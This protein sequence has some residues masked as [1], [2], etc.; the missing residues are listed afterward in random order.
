MNKNFV[1]NKEILSLNNQLFDGF[2]IEELEVR[3]ETDPLMF[4]QFFGLSPDVDIDG[5]PCNNLKTCPDLRC[6]I[7]S[8]PELK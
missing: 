5:C 1:K 4:S 3:L 8:C 7:D 2:D 6:V